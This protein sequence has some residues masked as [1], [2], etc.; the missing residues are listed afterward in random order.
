MKLHVLGLVSIDTLEFD[1]ST[2]YLGGGALSTAWVASLWGV[3]S[4]LYSIS[5][6]NAYTETINKNLLW[7]R[8][9]FSH[10]TLSRNKPMTRFNIARH[11]QDYQYKIINMNDSQT[12]LQQ[13]LNITADMQYIK[14]PVSNFIGLEH[15]VNTASINPQGTFN[16]TDFIKVL[17]TEG[18]IFLNSNELLLSSNVDF[19]SALQYIESWK[20]SFVITLGKSGSICYYADDANWYFCPSIQSIPYISALGCGDAFAGGFLAAYTKNQSSIVDCMFYGTLSAYLTTYSPNN[21]VS[22]WLDD[23]CD[24][25]AFEELKKSIRCFRFSNELVKFLQSNKGSVV[26]LEKTPC[27]SQKFD[28]RLDDKL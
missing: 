5:C 7:N 25:I 3:P 10:I 22:V 1:G 13:F 19:L 28:W 16:L 12:E 11:N 6:E 8:D 17:R 9:L 20:Q 2:S 18:F 14:L 24:M 4:T 15:M 23:I 26:V 21:L 27:I